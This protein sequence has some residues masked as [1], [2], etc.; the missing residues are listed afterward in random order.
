[1]A[2]REE[3][4]VSYSTPTTEE[5]EAW[6]AGELSSEDYFRFAR[7]RQHQIARAE[8]TARLTEAYRPFYISNL[9]RQAGKTAIRLFSRDH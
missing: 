9:L 3:F 7:E 6:I 2:E 1:M 4:G 5:S 8:V